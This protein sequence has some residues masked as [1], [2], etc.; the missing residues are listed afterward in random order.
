[1]RYLQVY[2]LDK[3]QV[4]IGGTGVGAGEVGWLVVLGVTAL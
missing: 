1:M 3:R 2:F 4:T